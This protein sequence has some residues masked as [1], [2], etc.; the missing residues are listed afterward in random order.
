M[1]H[2][3]LFLSKQ[4]N[5]PSTTR[6]RNETRATRIIK[7]TENEKHFRAAIELYITEFYVNK[8]PAYTTL[9]TATW[10]VSSNFHLHRTP[11]YL[12][13]VNDDDNNNNRSA[14]SFWM[15]NSLARVGE[16]F[17]FIKLASMMFRD[18]IFLFC[19]ILFFFFISPSTTQRQC[20]CRQHTASAEQNFSWK[21]SFSSLHNN[22]EVGFNSHWILRLQF[23]FHIYEKGGEEERRSIE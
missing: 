2:W 15:E 19:F 18:D 5:Q 7:R 21:F 11:D 22:G 8:S 1:T 13:K 16:L 9:K 23:P 4:F 12:I 20:T 17:M 6:Q 14:K 10:N 3:T